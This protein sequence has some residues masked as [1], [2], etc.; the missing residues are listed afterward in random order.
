MATLITLAQYRM[1]NDHM[2]G[3]WGWG[4]AALMLIALIAVVAL[5]VWLVRSTS[6]GHSHPQ[7]AAAA[8]AGETPMQILDRRLAQ[9]EIAPEEYKERAAILGKS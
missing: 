4:M 9:G 5:V 1:N 3:G 8:G 7:H 2:D 6:A